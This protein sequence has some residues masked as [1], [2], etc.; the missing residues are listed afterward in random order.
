MNV[1]VRLP[2]LLLTHLRIVLG[3]EHTVFTVDRWDELT[4]EVRRKSVDL[5]VAD[6]RAEGTVRLDEL[7]TLIRDFP[8]LPVVIYT[9][10]AP[11]TLGATVEDCAFDSYA[12]NVS[13]DDWNGTLNYRGSIVSLYYNHQA[14]GTYKCCRNVYDPPNR[15]YFFDEE[16]LD[17]ALLPEDTV[18][19]GFGQGYGY[20]PLVL[21]LLGLWWLWRHRPGR[22]RPARSGRTSA[23]A[24]APLCCPPPSPLRRGRWPGASTARRSRRAASGHAAAARPRVR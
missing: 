18:W 21:P 17:P 19:S 16:F 7:R 10:L 12:T 4:D 24:A 20:I 3:R 5:V 6:P 11:E 23:S 14:T 9:I 1:V 13:F 8:S 2:P 15:Q 22:P